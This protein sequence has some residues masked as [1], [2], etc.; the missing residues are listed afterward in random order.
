[1]SRRGGNRFVRVWLAPLVLVVAVGVM[2]GLLFWF[3][4]SWWV[5][6]GR[7]PSSDQRAADGTT[8]F[9]SAGMDYAAATGVMI[10]RVSDESLDAEALGLDDDEVRRVDPEVPVEVRILGADGALVLDFVDAVSVTTVDGAISRVE[11][12][13]WGS[14]RYRE[15]TALLDSRAETIGWTEEDLA[16]LEADL[17][18]AQRASDDGTYDAVLPPGRNIGADVT[19]RLSIDLNAASATLLIIVEQLAGG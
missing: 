14:G 5:D 12:E 2:A 9:T 19:A 7:A 6:P 3:Y 15:H 10:I 17:G 4:N 8:M 1:M 13:P 16:R 18:D 11:L